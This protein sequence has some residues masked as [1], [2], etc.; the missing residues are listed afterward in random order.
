MDGWVD[1]GGGRGGGETSIRHCRHRLARLLPR[2]L[3]GMKAG[4]ILTDTLP[5]QSPV[6]GAD[7]DSS[8]RGGV[9]VPARGRLRRDLLMPP[10]D[11]PWSQR[12]SADG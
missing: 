3:C 4:L 2:A 9:E 12:K 1:G 5:F 7:T 8:G 6:G 11:P 10:V